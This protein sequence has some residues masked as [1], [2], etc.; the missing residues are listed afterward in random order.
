ML[1]VIIRYFFVPFSSLE[2]SVQSHSSLFDFGI[3]CKDCH[4]VG[5]NFLDRLYSLIY[6]KLNVLQGA[7]CKLLT[8]IPVKG[9]L[10]RKSFPTCIP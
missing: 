9:V 8:S 10:S 4:S 5:L 3:A 6:I 2:L 7:I 1:S